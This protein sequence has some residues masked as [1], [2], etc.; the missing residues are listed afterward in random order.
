MEQAIRNINNM[1]KELDRILDQLEKLSLSLKFEQQL[2]R[3]PLNKIIADLESMVDLE[4]DAALI[5][6]GNYSTALN[7]LTFTDQFFDL[8]ISHLMHL[9]RNTQV[10]LTRQQDALISKINKQLMHV[11]GSLTLVL[12]MFDTNTE[13]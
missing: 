5:K 7:D 8:V 11:Q 2:L 4:Y 1:S 10:K 13:A 6:D 3:T 12:N 9:Q